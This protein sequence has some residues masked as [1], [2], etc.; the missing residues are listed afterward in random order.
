[1]N[2]I[3][4]LRIQ[5]EKM[6]ESMGGEKLEE[7]AANI[8]KDLQQQLNNILD[9]LAL[10]FA[11]RFVPLIST[12]QLSSNHFSSSLKPCISQSVRELGERLF[13]IKGNIQIKAGSSEADEVLRPLMDLLDGSLTMYAQSCE[14]TVLKRLLK[15]LWKIVIRTIEKTIVLP[16]INDKT[17]SFWLNSQESLL[18]IISRSDHLQKSYRQCQEYCCKRQNRGHGPTFQDSHYIEARC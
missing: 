6:F 8:L 14:K 15:E 4:Q 11:N 7:D 16:P 10:Q 12:S 13:S 17:V 9:E 18:K 3:Q 2:N 1:M 5:L